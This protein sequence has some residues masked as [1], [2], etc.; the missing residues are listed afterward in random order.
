MG[1]YEMV[2]AWLQM[3]TVQ[4]MRLHLLICLICHSSFLPYLAYFLDFLLTRLSS[5]SNKWS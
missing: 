3:Q 2:G 5:L 4:D 1:Q